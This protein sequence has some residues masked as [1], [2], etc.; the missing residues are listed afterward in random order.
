MLPLI[1]PRFMAQRSTEWAALGPADQ[2]EDKRPG[3]PGG[4]DR[5]WDTW[6]QAAVEPDEQKQNQMSSSP[7]LAEEMQ[8]SDLARCH[9]SSRRTPKGRQGRYRTTIRPG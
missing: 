5:S 9:R 3:A 6:D 4:Q 7:S 1:E 2:P 8:W